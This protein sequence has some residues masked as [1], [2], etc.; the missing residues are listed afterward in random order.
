MSMGPVKI[1]PPKRAED[2]GPSI[3]IG[4]QV[5]CSDGTEVPFVRSAK[6]HLVPDEFVR[7]EL[8]VITDCEE[9]WALPVLSEASM[10]A[11]AEHWGY[12]VRKR[13]EA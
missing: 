11:A 3:A 6:I 1:V 8:D 13:D 2:G 5:L 10:K 9:C 12:E 4:W 7:A